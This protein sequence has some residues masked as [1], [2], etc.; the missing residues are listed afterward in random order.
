[1][2]NRARFAKAANKRIVQEGLDRRKLERQMD[3]FED[4]MLRRINEN[5]DNA[6]WQ[7]QSD[8]A[9][10]HSREECN[11]RIA[12]RAEAAAV[13]RQMRKDTALGC[14]SFFAYVVVMLMLTAWTAFPVWAAATFIVC[15]APFLGLYL[16]RVHGLLPM[17]EKK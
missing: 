5:H 16:R 13:A 8:K 14:L 6:V 17:E 10:R 1:M 12:A 7:R 4:A 3:A 9:M 15:G 11:T 2:E